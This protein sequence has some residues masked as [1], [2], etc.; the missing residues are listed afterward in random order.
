MDFDL[1]EE[2]AF[3]MEKTR[4]TE[5]AAWNYL[6]AEEDFFEEKEASGADLSAIDEKELWGFISERSGLENDLAQKLYLAELE[7]FEK[8]GI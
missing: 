4:C 5:D 8:K 6:I 7:F 1:E 3:L 2:K